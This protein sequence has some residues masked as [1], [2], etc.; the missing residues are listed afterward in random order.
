VKTLVLVLGCR[1]APY[2]ALI[3]TS[4]KTWGAVHVDGV[5]VVYYYGG[6]TAERRGRHLFLPVPDD[7]GHVGL[8]TLAA[9]EHVLGLEFDLVFRANCSSYVD[10]PNLQRYV[11]EHGRGRGFYAG[12]IGAQ[13]GISFA[14]GSGYL[15]SRDLVELAVR[16]QATWDHS[17][18]DDVALGVVLA[19]HGVE[20]VPAPRVDYRT[21]GEVTEVDTTQFH[22]RCKTDS[23]RRLEDARLMIELHRSFCE[24][25]NLPVPRRL[26]GA[27]MGAWLGGRTGRLLARVN[28]SR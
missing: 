24:A 16:E 20:P 11:D 10:L 4:E 3:E 1:A 13:G 25:R 28:A 12:L 15:L 18:I 7:L 26:R 22:F 5:E 6:E 17:L 2:P 9:F 19:R 8:K 21:V 27:Q 23:W 14:S